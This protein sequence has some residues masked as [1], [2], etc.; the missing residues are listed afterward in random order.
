MSL[1]RPAS[2]WSQ[3]F[4]NIGFD[5]TLAPSP[6]TRN[7]DTHYLIALC[8]IVT[9]KLVREKTTGMPEVPE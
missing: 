8:L 9:T 6:T 4:S 1:N 5:M 2:H 3:P 7:W